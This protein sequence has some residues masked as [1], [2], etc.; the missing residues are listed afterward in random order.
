MK[1]FTG[2]G[3][4]T[5]ITVSGNNLSLGERQIVTVGR[6]LLS[7]KKIVLIDEATANIDKPTEDLIKQVPINLL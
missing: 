3:L 6:T 5:Q 4:E 7:K 2:D 1:S